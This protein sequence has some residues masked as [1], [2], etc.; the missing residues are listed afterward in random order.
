MFV[1]AYSEALDAAF[2]VVFESLRRNVFTSD[3]PASHDALRTLPLASLL[4]QIK[5]IAARL[6]PASLDTVVS[7]EVRDISS[8]PCLDSF[9]IAV[10]DAP[11][12]S[13]AGN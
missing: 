12:S 7:P 6:L 10:F 11:D 3:N 8:G 13:G 5:A 2:R 4:P 9:C 1:A